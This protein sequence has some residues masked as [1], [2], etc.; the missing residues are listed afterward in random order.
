M[1]D[2]A[3]CYSNESKY[4]INTHR[5]LK[6]TQFEKSSTMKHCFLFV[7]LVFLGCA[8]C[9]TTAN[10][11][12]KKTPK[13]FE[14]DMALTPEQ[15]NMLF[16]KTRNGVKDTRLRWPGAKVYFWFDSRIP[17][18]HRNLV[19]NALVHI[20]T[21][22]CVR[23]YQGA[24]PNNEYIL[25]TNNNAGCYSYIGYLRTAGQQ[26][27]LGPGCM[28]RGIIIHEFLHALGF[29]H[30]QS[31]YDRDTYVTINWKNI[32]SGYEYA[33]DKY[34]NQ[35]V[36]NFGVPYDYA[37]IMH[38]GP[39]AFSSNGK[40]TITAKLSG[41]DQMGQR[42]GLTYSDATKINRMYNC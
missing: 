25:V 12:S 28:Y 40:P 13:L 17:E 6:H 21:Y 39:Y 16:S 27:N 18:N 33:F 9:D 38:Y 22:T 1:I 7:A 41:G 14:G 2:E 34:T 35:Q 23:F 32:Q 10:P 30:E 42:E 11:E 20:Q 26:L 4:S 15:L 19:I 8:S 31:T 37:S 3:S 24:N 29:Y 36:N 5:H